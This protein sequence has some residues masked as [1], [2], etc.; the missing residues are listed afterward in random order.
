[1]RLPGSYRMEG[2]MPTEQRWK[3]KVSCEC[4]G[5]ESRYR[6]DWM[7]DGDT[8]LCPECA[9]YTVQSDG[10]VLCHAHHLPVIEWGYIQTLGNGLPNFCWGTDPDGGRWVQEDHGGTWRI[11]SQHVLNGVYNTVRIY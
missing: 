7:P 11:Y 10:E 8:W 6:S 2:E 4:C 9:D 5:W 3:E 1:M